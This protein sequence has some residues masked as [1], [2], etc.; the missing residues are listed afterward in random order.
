M[1]Y[2]GKFAPQNNI[3]ADCIVEKIFSK[4]DLIKPN[5]TF[6]IKK[7][8]P[9]K[10]GLGSASSNAAAVIR[11]LEKLEYN[12]KLSIQLSNKLWK[13]RD[14]KKFNIDLFDKEGIHL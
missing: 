10:S 14:I 4:Y 6:T 9:I 3:F 5:Y 1:K 7:N 12:K 11:I 8:I 13:D 2:I